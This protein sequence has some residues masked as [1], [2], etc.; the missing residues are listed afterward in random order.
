MKEDFAPG[1][2]VIT[3]YPNERYNNLPGII[4]QKVRESS[5]CP[6]PSGGYWVNLGPEGMHFFREEELSRMTIK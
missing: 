4:Y 1:L 2:C 6:Y 3:R 5:Y